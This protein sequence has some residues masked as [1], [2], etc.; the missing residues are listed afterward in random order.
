[1][2]MVKISNTVNFSIPKLGS[3]GTTAREI[4]RLDKNAPV[5]LGIVTAFNRK[6]T[7]NAVNF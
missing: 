6:F 2:T 5:F 7:N 3:Q 1:M 4:R